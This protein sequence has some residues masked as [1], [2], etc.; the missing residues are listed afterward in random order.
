MSA[1]RTF[2]I[3][4]AAA[5]HDGE[6]LNAL[7]LVDLAEHIGAD[8]VKFQWTSSPERMVARRRAPEYLSAYEALAFP[9]KWLSELADYVAEHCSIELMYTVY[10]PEDVAAIK[11]HVRQ[12]KVAS[13]E[14]I[15]G[16]L[17]ET[18]GTSPK[19]VS[20]GMQD[21]DT[22]AR[23]REVLHP[24]DAILH[25]VS[26]YPCPDD[27][28]NLRAVRALWQFGE[29]VKAG[30]SDHTR[31]PWAGALAVAAGAEGVEFHVR[32]DDTLRTNADYRVSRSP[33]EARKYVANIRL[34]ERMLGDGIKRV[35][36]CEEPMLRYLVTPS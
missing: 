7:R 5:C 31:H 9:E 26:A 25:C 23:Y 4:E 21:H 2:V 14:A 34:A 17:L 28:A 35:M 3:A 1:C 19:I 13:F 33:A 36:P 30:V 10:L 29:A 20:T 27:Q 32:L 24:G 15:S 8:A 12:F 6:F 11:P 22:W 16:D 18:I